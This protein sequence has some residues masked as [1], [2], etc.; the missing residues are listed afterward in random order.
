MSRETHLYNV[1][2]HH[3][4]DHSKEIISSSE[5]QSYLLRVRRA[6]NAIKSIFA[7]ILAVH[8]NDRRFPDVMEEE[9]EEGNIELEDITCSACGEMEAEDNDILLCDKEGCYRAYHQKCLVPNINN[10]ALQSEK[11]WFCWECETVNN[12]LVRQS[13]C[14]LVR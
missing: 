14:I 13:L 11:D 5:L 3:R 2:T 4:K 8:A 6:E 7:E 1:Y 10:E 12:C 9:D